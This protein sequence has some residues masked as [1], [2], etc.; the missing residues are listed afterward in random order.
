M[1]RKPLASTIVSLLSSFLVAQ[2]R[3]YEPSTGVDLGTLG[4]D[5]RPSRAPPRIL[6]VDELC[7]DLQ[8][9]DQV[10]VFVGYKDNKK[11]RAHVQKYSAVSQNDDFDE[12]GAV[13]VKLSKQQLKELEKDPEIDYIERNDML[14]PMVQH[15][16]YGIEL[17]NSQW[18]YPMPRQASAGSCK[19][20]ESFKIAI[21]DSGVNAGHKGLP[22]SGTRDHGCIGKSFGGAAPWYLDDF[23][24]GKIG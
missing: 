2:G 17:T 4:D 5:G 16:T 22:C 1:R 24:H 14:Y 8:E 21:I 18:E 23:G 12:V 11:G 9:E 19:N 15:T 20:K 6:S 3:L 10:D 13:A 7:R